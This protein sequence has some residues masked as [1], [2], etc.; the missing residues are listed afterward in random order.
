MCTYG[1]HIYVIQIFHTLS[2]LLMLLTIIIGV[3]YKYSLVFFSFAVFHLLMALHRNYQSEIRF[4][5]V[6]CINGCGMCMYVYVYCNV[7]PWRDRQT[8]TRYHL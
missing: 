1:L 6:H 2:Y 8:H 5:S 7:V 3:L 4:I